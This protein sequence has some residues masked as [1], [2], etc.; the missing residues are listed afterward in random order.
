MSL[1][2][3]YLHLQRSKPDEIQ[4]KARR[5]AVYRGRAEQ[6]EP[7][8]LLR[9]EDGCLQPPPVICGYFWKVPAV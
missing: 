8:A 2:L 5:L 9:R 1:H 4:P 3:E 7:L 6:P